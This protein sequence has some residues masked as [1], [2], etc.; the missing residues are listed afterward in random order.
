M[1]EALSLRDGFWSLQPLRVRGLLFS[2][3]GSH[4]VCRK[5]RFACVQWP[6]LAVVR[7]NRASS[8]GN[9]FGGGSRTAPELRWKRCFADVVFRILRYLRGAS[10]FGGWEDL[11]N[12]WARAGILRVAF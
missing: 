8:S 5:C 3:S 7:E 11:R 6:F 9:V 4:R 12:T 2:G 10:D 1:F